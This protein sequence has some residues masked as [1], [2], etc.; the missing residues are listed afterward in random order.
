MVP[1]LGFLS[2]NGCDK[3]G[4]PEKWLRTGVWNPEKN[5]R[6]Q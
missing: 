1:F 5:G 4:A 2:Y 6:L 3:L